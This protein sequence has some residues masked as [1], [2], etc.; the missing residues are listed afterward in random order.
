MVALAFGPVTAATGAS[1]AKTTVPPA[2]PGPFPPRPALRVRPG[3]SPRLCAGTRL[4]SLIVSAEPTVMSLAAQIMMFPTVLVIAPAAASTT[5]R[6]AASETLP[7]VV[8]IAALTFT[9][10]PQQATRLPLVAVI[11]WLMLTSRLALSVR[12]VAL[13]EA[14]Q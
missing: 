7:L 2:T 6:P 13:D 9:S 10:R 12:V 14:T 1:G 4:P 5:L 11:A 3:A 8:V